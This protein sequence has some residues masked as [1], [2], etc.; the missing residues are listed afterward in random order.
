MPS[1]QVVLFD[2]GGT[3]L[4]YEQ[5][6]ENTF[7]ALNERSMR[8]FL[9]AAAASGAKIP[10][11]NVAVRAVGRMA[12]AMEAKAARA[13]HANSAENVIRE[14]LEAVD[15][16]LSSK[17]WNAG[18]AAYYEVISGIVTPVS[19][20]TREVLAK[21]IGQGR[22]LGLVSNTLWAPEIHDADL[23]RF[24]LLEYLPVRIYS[25]VAGIV[26]PHPGIYRQALD[27]LDVA[28]AE[29]VFVGDK[30]G[31]DV[32]GP[33][34]IGMRAVLLVSPYRVEENAEIQPDA[35]IQSLAELPDLLV[36]WDCAI[37]SQLPIS[38][39]V[40]DECNPTA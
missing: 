20:D 24:G 2:L 8:A 35:R 27:R 33:Q 28:P 36:A 1:I 29:A 4:H 14:G 34:K 3:L 30:L 10:D 32:A 18:L 31:V 21:L 37:E 16:K 40:S 23:A 11:P 19:G 12:A 38:G 25:S 5:P 13:Q 17:A 39:A 15:I 7:N 9:S 22:S 6:P 26:K